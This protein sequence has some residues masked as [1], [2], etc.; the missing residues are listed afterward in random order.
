MFECLQVQYN[1]NKNKFNGFKAIISEW[2]KSISKWIKYLFCEGIIVLLNKFLYNFIVCNCYL[3]RI[4]MLQDSENKSILKRLGLSKLINKK[5]NG[6]T[7][8]MQS[9]MIFPGV[10]LV[11]NEYEGNE[12]KCEHQ[13]LENILQINY[14][15]E[16]RLGWRLHNGDYIYLAENDIS[17]HMVNNCALSSIT[18]PLK[19]Y[20]GIS[21]FIDLTE[22]DIDKSVVLKQM[23]LNLMQLKQKFCR[24]NKTTVLP[25]TNNIKNLF[26]LLNLVPEEYKAMYFKLKFEEIMMFLA[27]LDLSKITEKQIYPA[28]TVD[29]IKRIH[30]KLIANLK[31]R[32][33][34]EILSKEFL[35]NTS[36]LKQV[37]KVVYGKPI[38]QYMKD[39]RMHEA[40]NLLCQ[41]NM[42]VK[43][44]AEALGYENQSKFATAFKEIMQISPT[45]YRSYYKMEQEKN[46][47]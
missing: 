35:I 40:A 47:K 3:G 42:T 21:I 34:I 23:N 5:I 38:A 33:T 10:E 14:C 30:A 27:L 2:I 22:F 12:L 37:F 1:K 7:A 17:L 24:N 41:T 9:Y 39:Y 43:E 44:V 6:I 18:L 8:M 45:Q 31:Q 4:F 29:T 19:H 46:E 25:A 13:A 28:C 16:G 26:A 15:L 11:L 36:T 32:P 20:K